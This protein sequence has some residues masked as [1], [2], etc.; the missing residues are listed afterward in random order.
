MVVSGS[1]YF[2]LNA[3]HRTTQ[4]AQK[5]KKLSSKSLPATASVASDDRSHLSS[6]FSLAAVLVSR[7]ECRNAPCFAVQRGRRVSASWKSIRPG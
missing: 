1:S 5:P 7:D 3:L 4:T 2:L 6:G